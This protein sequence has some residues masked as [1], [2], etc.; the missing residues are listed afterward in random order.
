[1]GLSLAML[2]FAMLTLSA[3]DAE[4][5]WSVFLPVGNDR[6]FHNEQVDRKEKVLEKRLL[7]MFCI[8]CFICGIPLCARGGIFIFH[9]IENLNANWNSF[10]LSLI[11]VVIVCYV[12]V[13]L[14]LLVVFFLYEYIWSNYRTLHLQ[15][16]SDVSPA[17]LFWK[18]TKHFFVLWVVTSSTHGPYLVPLFW[19]RFVWATLPIFRAYGLLLA[20]IWRYERVS[21]NGHTLPW[22]YET[23][24]WIV[25]IGPLFV[26]FNILYTVYDAKQN[27]KPWRSVVSTCNWRHKKKEEESKQ[28]QH[29]VDDD[30]DYCTSIHYPRSFCQIQ[31]NF[32]KI[33]VTCVEDDPSYDR[34]REKIREM[35]EKMS[36]DVKVMESEEDRQE[37]EQWLGGASNQ[38]ISNEEAE[39]QEEETD[40]Q[41]SQ[42]KEDDTRPTGRIKDWQA[43]QC[44]WPEGVPKARP[45]LSKDASIQSTLE[46]IDR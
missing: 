13:K 5:A 18:Q 29:T 14:I 45:K 35:E 24:A 4:F 6:R 37:I 33:S 2:F 3:L 17:Y 39:E 38:S 20:S 43:K 12:Y 19:Y 15:I 9:A 8:F 46:P 36:A 40:D 28:P 42:V 16:S 22:F 44:E 10:S 25:M 1:M 26:P 21:F 41:F 7:I 27:G 23:I 31:Q 34:V 11:Q 30:N 32:P